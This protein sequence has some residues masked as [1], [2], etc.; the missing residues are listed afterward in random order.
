MALAL[1]ENLQGGGV[2]GGVSSSS[3]T[4]RNPFDELVDDL[5]K[6]LGPSSGIDSADVDKDEL[7]KRMERYVSDEKECMFMLKLIKLYA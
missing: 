2:G 6:M 1:S 4:P 3:T 7:Q 5:E